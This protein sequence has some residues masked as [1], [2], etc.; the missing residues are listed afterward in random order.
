[1]RWLVTSHKSAKTTD[2]SIGW[3]RHVA[4]ILPPLLP[5][6]PH[7]LSLSLSLSLSPNPCPV[8]LSLS[9]LLSR[10]GGCIAFVMAPVEEEC[11]TG[12][13]A[14]EESSGEFGSGLLKKLLSEN[15]GLVPYKWNFKLIWI[16][17]RVE[18]YIIP[19]I[20]QND[21][22][23]PDQIPRKETWQPHIA[24]VTRIQQQQF[25]HLKKNPQRI[26]KGSQPF[27]ASISKH[28]W[29]NHRG[30]AQRRIDRRKTIIQPTIQGSHGQPDES[31]ESAK[32]PERIPRKW[33]DGELI[34]HVR[35]SFVRLRKLE[36]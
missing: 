22:K 26:W 12:G 27:P 8:S 15:L 30:N 2:K 23:N 4:P 7:S 11:L 19:R 25:R 24:N 5:S 28:N 17:L 32:N 33:M 13:A 14:S 34:G 20:A 18:R 6:L 31:Q 1:M 3:I 10:F 16:E 36:P 29:K 35:G 9:L 21:R